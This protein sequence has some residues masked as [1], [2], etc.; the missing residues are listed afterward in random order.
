MGRGSQWGATWASKKIGLRRPWA[1]RPLP[2]GGQ[3]EP[4]KLNFLGPTWDPSWEGLGGAWTPKSDFFQVRL[5]R[6][7]R[8]HPWKNFRSAAPASRW[9]RVRRGPQDAPRRLQMRFFRAPIPITPGRNFRSAAPASRW[10]RVR[11]G[12]QD[13]PRRPKMRF[14][15]AQRT[16]SKLD[17]KKSLLGVQAPPRPR[18]DGSQVGGQNNQFWTPKLASIWGGG[19]SPR[20]PQ[21][22]FFGGPSCPS[23]TAPHQKK[24]IGF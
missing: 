13:A 18:Q 16:P 9:L 24:K 4:P 3:L 6:R 10:L 19:W 11:R 22:F 1:P 8:D 14:Y 2:D 12:P 20:A 15:R 21:S 5:R 23:K 7:S 17:L